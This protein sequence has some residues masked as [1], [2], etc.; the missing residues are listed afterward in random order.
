MFKDITSRH[1]DLSSATWEVAIMLAG[2]FLLGF[3]FCY[4][5]NKSRDED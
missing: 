2:A 5:R 3:L 4:L 1:P